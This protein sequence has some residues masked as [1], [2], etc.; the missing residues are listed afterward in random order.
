MNLFAL[1]WILWAGGFAN[2]VVLFS[3][4][5]YRGRW[6]GFPLFTL[7]TG[8]AAIITIVMYFVYRFASQAW[9]ARCYYAFGFADGLLQIAVVVEIARI[10]MRPT[11]TWVRDAKK[12]FTLG[13]GI[14]VLLAVALAAAISPPTSDSFLSMGVRFGVFVGALICELFIVVAFTSNQLGLGWRN[15]VMSLILGWSAEQ[16]T[17]IAVDALHSFFGT[18]FHYRDFDHVRMIVLQASQIYWMVQFWRDEPARRPIPPEL[19]AY[20]RDLHIRVQ[21][22]LDT[23][24][25]QR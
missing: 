8:Y 23:V 4:L 15:H 1:D 3:I 9:Y 2:T 5:L 7:Y 21:K 16:G 22:N 13:A 14:G 17:A 24:G 11:G 18:H 19:A 6:K 20:I 25:A 10:V 12:Q